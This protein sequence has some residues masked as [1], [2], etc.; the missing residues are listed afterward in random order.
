MGGEEIPLPLSAVQERELEVVGT[1]RYANTW[2]TAI[3][4]AASGRVDLERLVTGTY[5]LDQT[6]DAL[7]AGRRSQQAIKAVVHPQT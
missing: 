6:A 7:T 3:A 2:P 1:F 4:L 5:R